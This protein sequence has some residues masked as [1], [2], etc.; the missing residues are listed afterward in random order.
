MTHELVNLGVVAACIDVSKMEEGQ[1]LRLAFRLLST[2]WV[3]KHFTQTFSSVKR[4]LLLEVEDFFLWKIK[5][6]Y[7]YMYVFCGDIL[8]WLSILLMF[9]F[10]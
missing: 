7:L 8:S 10:E 6:S 4:Y 9:S 2:I 5:F 1:L 3:V